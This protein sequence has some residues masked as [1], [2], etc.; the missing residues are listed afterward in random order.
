VREVL[1]ALTDDLIHNYRA[2]RTRIA[3]EVAEK[4]CALRADKNSLPIER[5][6]FA[7]VGLRR[8]LEELVDLVVEDIHSKEIDKQEA[9]RGFMSHVGDL[10]IPL[11]VKIVLTSRDRALRSLAAEQLKHF[12][13]AGARALSSQLNMGNTTN[14]LFNVISVL[15]TVGSEEILEAL[16]TLVRYPDPD[17]RH[18]IVRIL[19]RLPGDKSSELALLFLRD[20]KE[21]IRRLAADLL[22]DRKYAP[23]VMPL[24]GLL[25][26][27]S[28]AE[29]ETVSLVLGRIGDPV[30]A[31]PLGQLLKEKRLLFSKDKG[32]RETVRIHAAWALAQLGATG[33]AHLLPYREDENPAVRD[34][35]IKAAQ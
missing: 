25:P 19:A 6:E 12:G 28:V 33:R 21:S 31:E 18:G 35:A 7:G 1:E 9:A 24:L 14:A 26:R 3:L 16:G 32:N 17:L 11:F 22:G 27:A 5:P 10:A 15:G 34:I 30:A 20:E 2:R 4:L 29:A 8:A 13:V 23:A